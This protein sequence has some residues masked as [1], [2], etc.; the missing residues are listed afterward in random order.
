MEEEKSRLERIEEKLDEISKEKTKKKSERGFRLPSK[1]KVR[2]KRAKENYVTILKINENK[3][4]EF[5]KEKVQDQTIL[6]DGIP[7]I[8]GAEYVMNYK[9]SPLIILPNWSVEPFSPYK[10]YQSSLDNGSNSA[11]YRLLM[12][13]M[14]SEALKIGKKIGGLG[15]GIGALAIG[16]IILY[17][18]LTGGK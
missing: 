3:N 12:N 14:Q 15:I 1:A 10:S 18:L 4:V 13:R 5:I 7:R 6:V 17:A 8:L 2:G 16:G 9:R 11:G